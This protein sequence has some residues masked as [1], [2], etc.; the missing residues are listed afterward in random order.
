M[1]Q[2]WG[3]PYGGDGRSPPTKGYYFSL[4]QIKIFMLKPNENFIFKFSYWLMLY[5]FFHFIPF[6]HIDHANFDFNWGSIVTC[7]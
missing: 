5:D 1:K 3:F 2:Q 4:H 7:F 6:V